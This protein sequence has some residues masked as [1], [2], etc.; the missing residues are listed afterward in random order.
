MKSDQSIKN[1]YVRTDVY[2]CDRSILKNFDWIMLSK[3]FLT[4]PSYYSWNRLSPFDFVLGIRYVELRWLIG[5]AMNI[6]ADRMSTEN[7]K[8]KDI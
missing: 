4:D 2:V 6:H 3:I 8:P 1:P 5:N 7:P